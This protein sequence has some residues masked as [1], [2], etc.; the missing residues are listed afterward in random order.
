MKR[1]IFLR[2]LRPRRRGEGVVA[3]GDRDTFQLVSERTIVLQPVRAGEMARVGP[4]QV[5]ERY[6]VEPKQVPDFIALRGDASDKIPGAKGVGPKGAAA[7]L[8]KYG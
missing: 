8:R 4:E 2:Q 1:T 3:S 6:G 7:L 5:R